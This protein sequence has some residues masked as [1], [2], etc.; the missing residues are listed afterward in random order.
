MFVDSKYKSC[1]TLLFS[2]L[3]ATFLYNYKF[4]KPKHYFL[5]TCGLFAVLVL[6]VLWVFQPALIYSEKKNSLVSPL[7]NELNLKENDQV[8]LLDFWLPFVERFT[9]K[10]DSSLAATSRSVLIYDLQNNKVLFEKDADQK[11]PMASLTK[12]MTAIIALENPKKDNHYLVKPEY[13]VGEDTM[14]LS[15]GEVLGLEELTYGLMLPSGNDAAEVLADNFPGGRDTF[16]KAMNNKAVA[17]GLSN[18]RFSNPSGLQGDGAQYT[19]ASEMVVIT[20]FAL[21]NFPVFRKVSATYQR[22]IPATST[23]K[24]FFL[25]NATNLLSTYPGVKGVKTG[26]TPEAGLCLVTYLE[27]KDQKIIGVM[28]NSQNRRGEMKELLDYSLKKLGVTPPPFEG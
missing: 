4:M 2:N 1:E 24:Y 14:G 6:I 8:R 16:I 15:A 18:T 25:E 12:I 10:E 22:E 23:H 11:L 9:E 3:E 26:F 20:R 17:L 7:P 27:Y 5:L 13:L 19:N 21:E 28:L